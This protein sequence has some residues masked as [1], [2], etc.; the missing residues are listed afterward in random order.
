MV[1]LAAIKQGQSANGKH[2]YCLFVF[3]CFFFLP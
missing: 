3:F 2:T 1:Q